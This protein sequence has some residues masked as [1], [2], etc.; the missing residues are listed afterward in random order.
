M[1]LL[2]GW[3]WGWSQRL[4]EQSA[5][6]RASRLA[7]ESTFGAGV[8]GVCLTASERDDF[9]FGEGSA[10]V[11]AFHR[12][13]PF[14]LCCEPRQSAKV[15]KGGT[16]LREGPTVRVASTDQGLLHVIGRYFP[17]W[18]GSFVPRFVTGGPTKS[19]RFAVRLSFQDDPYISQCDS[20]GLPQLS[21]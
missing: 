19:V 13:V 4:L 10:A 20:T 17:G 14:R 12:K 5:A 21:L 8:V 3:G 6:V 15:T 7:L 18:R 9:T 1:S 2:L 11:D 16:K